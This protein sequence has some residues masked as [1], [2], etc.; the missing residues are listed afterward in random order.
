MSSERTW[1]LI[2]DGGHAR[3]FEAQGNRSDLVPVQR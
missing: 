3:V 1:V 2:A